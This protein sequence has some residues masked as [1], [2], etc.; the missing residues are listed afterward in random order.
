MIN[1]MITVAISLNVIIK[2]AQNIYGVSQ[3]TQ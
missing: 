3:D 1:A 2:T